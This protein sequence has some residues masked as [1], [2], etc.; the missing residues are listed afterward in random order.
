M[1]QVKERAKGW[2]VELKGRLFSIDNQCPSTTKAKAAEKENINK[3][4]KLEHKIN[5]HIEICKEGGK[6]GG[7]KTP[8]VLITLFAE[9]NPE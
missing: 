5:A 3:V 8:S 2:G 4:V 7:G 1:A 9:N 6:D